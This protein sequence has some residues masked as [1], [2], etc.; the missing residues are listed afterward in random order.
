MSGFQKIIIALFLSL[1]LS[2]SYY[3]LT[4]L[5]ELGVGE[6]GACG[7]DPGLIVLSAHKNRTIFPDVED[8]ALGACREGERKFRKVVEDV[9]HDGHRADIPELQAGPLEVVRPLKCPLQVGYWCFKEGCVLE[10][11][12][13]RIRGESTQR[14]RGCTRVRGC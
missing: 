9:W 1:S 14:L 5:F 10:C 8:L 13:G 3:T 7:A 4:N 2:L 12:R 6:W 11:G